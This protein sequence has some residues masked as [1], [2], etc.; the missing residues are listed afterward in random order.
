MS[1]L[2]DS[3][4]LWRIFGTSSALTYVELPAFFV[5]RASDD[6]LEALRVL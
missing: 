1:K 5:L 2:P 6:I 3:E 4:E